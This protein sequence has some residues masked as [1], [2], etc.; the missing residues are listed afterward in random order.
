MIGRYSHLDLN[1]AGIR[2]GVLHDFTAGLNWYVTSH[3]R[4]MFNY[5]VAHPEGFDYQQSLQARFQLV[6]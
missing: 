2:G 5:I 6:F 4:V 3:A 1:S